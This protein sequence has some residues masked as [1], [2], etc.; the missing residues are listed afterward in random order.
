MVKHQNISLSYNHDGM[1][2]VRGCCTK[3][4]GKL[5]VLKNNQENLVEQEKVVEGT[6]E[7]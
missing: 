6:K 7:F 4:N 1:S 5:V 2:D 3:G